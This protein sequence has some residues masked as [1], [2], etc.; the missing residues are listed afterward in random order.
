MFGLLPSVCLPTDHTAPDGM[1]LSQL[2][3]RESSTQLG[4]TRRTGT[5]RGNDSRCQLWLSYGFFKLQN[6]LT[7]GGI[8]SSAAD[9][10][11]GLDSEMGVSAYTEFELIRHNGS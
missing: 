5:W 2:E 4:S 1:A 7:K 10:I 11:A 6:R 9:E 3:S 8:R